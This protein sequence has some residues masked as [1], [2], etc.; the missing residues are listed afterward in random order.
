MENRKHSNDSY[1]IYSQANRFLKVG[2]L[3][4]G[5]KTPSST[6]VFSFSSKGPFLRAFCG[7]AWAPQDKAFPPPLAHRA[8]GAASGRGSHPEPAGSRAPHSCTLAPRPAGA[9][10]G[11]PRPETS[12]RGDAWAAA[13][14]SSLQPLPRPPPRSR[15]ALSRRSGRTPGRRQAQPSWGHSPR[16][17]ARG[18]GSSCRVAQ[19]SGEEE[20]AR[21]AQGARAHARRPTLKQSPRSASVADRREARAGGIRGGP[22][23]PR[24]YSP[25]LPRGDGRGAWPAARRVQT[26]PKQP[27][28]GRL[29]PAPGAKA[30]AGC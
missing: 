24:E 27:K 2:Q 8:A 30:D 16:A 1:I 14:V 4:S 18:A 11:A 17:S 7:P 9:P 19:G 29:A 15:G 22:G 20:G 3:V 5:N 26:G 10:K 12:A 6:Q 25:G 13:C 21:R 23:R 28:G